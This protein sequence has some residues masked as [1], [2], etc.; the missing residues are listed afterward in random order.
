MDKR[1]KQYYLLFTLLIVP[2]LLFSKNNK[3][4]AIWNDDP[5]TTMTIG[6]SQYSFTGAIVY[7]DTQNHGQKAKSYSYTKKVDR[8][9]RFRDMNNQFARLKNLK[10][11]TKY[12][13][14]I[15]D[16]EG[17]SDVF[18]FRTA[19]NTSDKRLSIIAGGDSR[20]HRL[21]RQ[22]ANK[23]VAKLRPHCV[24]FGGDMTSSDNS[25]QWQEWLNDWQLTITSDNQLIPIIPARGNH[26]YSNGTIM[27][28]FDAP[29]ANVYYGLSI[30]G[31]LLR[32]YTLNSLI[33]PGGNQS[34]WLE[35]DLKIYERAIWKMAQYHHPIRPHTS[36]KSEKQKQYTNWANLFYKYQVQLVVEC[37]AHV[38]KTTYPI[39]PSYEEGSVEGFIRDDERGTVYA[40]EGCWGAP[41]RKN[42]DDKNWTRAS[43]S[44]NQIKWIWIDKEKIE[45]RTIKTDNSNDVSALSASDIFKMPKNINLWQPKTGSVVRI[46][47]KNKKTTKKETASIV[48]KTVPKPSRKKAKPAKKSQKKKGRPFVLTNLRANLTAK[49]IEIQWQ[50]KSCPDGAKCEIQRSGSRQANGFK[51]FATLDLKGTRDV[52]GYRLE[53]DRKEI[54]KKPFVFYQLKTTLANGYVHYSDKAIVVTQSWESYEKALNTNELLIYVEYKLED[55]CD[56]TMNVFNENGSLVS[57]EVYPNQIM[58]S[59]IRTL[60]SPSYKKGKYLVEVQGSKGFLKYLW[61]EQK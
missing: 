20:N 46:F 32:T 51:T 5:A 21:G 12:Y 34:K 36:R 25:K 10:P 43:G 55:I 30:G 48:K 42:N 8:K 27:K 58:G 14:T 54:G 50:T 35:L 37:D 23:L 22:N 53:D 2:C 61:F 47:K 19:P 16:S 60:E 9:E 13:F 52:K 26:E 29:N 40:G 59:H 44:F 11:N 4:R 1:K 39:R 31:D 18:W 33:A 3:Y 24:M 56:I 7:Y 41:L 38:C 17:T 28:I 45:I 15:K 49:N 6:W 57:Q